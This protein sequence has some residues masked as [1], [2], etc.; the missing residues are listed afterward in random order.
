[1]SINVNVGGNTGPLERDVRAAMDRINRAGGLKIRVD[2]KGVTQP[3]GNMKRSADEFTKSLEASNAR[4]LAFGASVGMINAVSNAFKGLVEQTMK[5]E[6]NLTDINVVM[7][8]T[9]K[10]LDKF[11]GGLFKVAA[12]T[13]AGFQAASEAATEFARQGLSVAETLKRTKDALVLTRLTG[14]K[15][16]ESVK[17][18][19]AAMNTFKGEVH[20]STVLVSKFAAVDVKFAVSAEDFAQA[21]ARAGASARDA[22]VD[23]N[24]LIGI[25]TAVQERTARGGAVIGNAFKT[26][27]TRLRRSSTLQELENIGIAVRDVN[28]AT[29]PAMRILEKLAGKYDHL[30]DAQKSYIAQNVAGVFQINMLKAAMA[31]LGQANNVTAQATAI[32]SKATDESTQKNEQLRNTMSALAAETGVAIQE[33]AKKIGDIAL[34]PGI[35]KI[36]DGIKG[37]ADWANNLLG[38]G[39]KEGNRFAK[40]LL[41][42][43]GSFISGPGLILITAVVSKLFVNAAKYGLSSLNSLLGMNKAATAR[44]QTEQAILQVMASNEALSKEMLR[45]DIS[46][47]KKEQMILN[48]IRQQTTEAQKLVAVS[49]QLSIPLIRQGVQPNLSLRRAEGFIPNFAADKSERQLA[50]Q[51]GYSAGAIKQMNIPGVGDVTYN[52]AETVKKFPGMTQPAIMPPEESRAAGPYAAAFM[53]A[54]GF[55]PYAGHGYVPNYADQ[56]WATSVAAGKWHNDLGTASG[57]DFIKSHGGE[58]AAAAKLKAYVAKNPAAMALSPAKLFAQHNLRSTKAMTK[59]DA[60]A[61]MLVPQEGYKSMSTGR[62]GMSRY[63]KKGHTLEWPVHAITSKGKMKDA[64][65]EKSL[66]NKIDSVGGNYALNLVKAL[67][68]PDFGNPEGAKKAFRKKWDSDKAGGATGAMGSMVG[69]IFEAATNA[70]L[71]Y[72]AEDKDSAEGDFD[73]RGGDW[74]KIK[75]A[76]N[77]PG[78]LRYMLADYKNNS[79]SS[80][81]RESFYKKVMAQKKYFNRSSK[82]AKSSKQGLAAAAMGYIPNYANPLS[83]AIGRERG[84][85]VPVSKIRVGSHRALQAS[86]NPMGLGVTNTTDEPRGLKDVFGADGFV[87]NYAIGDWIGGTKMGQA[88]GSA[89]GIENAESAAQKL[90]DQYEKLT[91]KVSGAKDAHKNSNKTLSKRVKEEDKL[92]KEVRQLKDEQA[93]LRRQK[94]RSSHITAQL[95]KKEQDLAAA[96][97]RTQAARTKSSHISS[98]LSAKESALAATTTQL[99]SARKTARRRT[100]MAGGRAN[101]GMGLMMSAHMISGMIQQSDP[102]GTDKF[103]QGSSG[104]LSGAT[105]GAMVGAAIGSIIPGVGTALGGL[106]GAAIGAGIG[107]KNG[108]DNAQKALDE[109][110]KA[111]EEAARALKEA[112]EATNATAT[113]QV[114]INSILRSELLKSSVGFS[115]TRGQVGFNSFDMSKRS[116][117]GLLGREQMR[118]AGYLGLPGTNPNI[119]H[120]VGSVIDTLQRPGVVKS[121]GSK[122]DSISEIFL[123]LSQGKNTDIKKA[124]VQK[125]LE[126]ESSVIGSLRSA[127]RMFTGVDHTKNTDYD[128]DRNLQISNGIPMKRQSVIVDDPDLGQRLDHTMIP[129]TDREYA[130]NIMVDELSKVLKTSGKDKDQANFA[131]NNDSVFKSMPKDF[132]DR[133]ISQVNA[134]DGDHEDAQHIISS[135]FGPT[136]MSEYEKSLNAGGFNAQRGIAGGLLRNSGGSSYIDIKKVGKEEQERINISNKDLATIIDG[137]EGEAAGVLKKLGAASGPDDIQRIRKKLIEELEASAKEQTASKEGVIKN[138]HY[139]MVE[140]KIQQAKN[141]TLA[142][143]KRAHESETAK[144]KRLNDLLGAEITAEQKVLDAYDQ[145][146]ADI[147]KSISGK[148]TTADSAFSSGLF[149]AITSSSTSKIQFNTLFGSAAENKGQ[150][151]DD[152]V[153]RLTGLF[154]QDGK[155]KEE[156]AN[157][158]AKGFAA[159]LKKAYENTDENADNGTRLAHAFSQLNAELVMSVIKSEEF[160][161]NNAELERKVAKTADLH[162]ETN[163]ELDKEET[164]LTTQ[165]ILAKQAQET[166]AKTK[167]EHK[168]TNKILD[169]RSKMISNLNSLEK[170]SLDLAKKRRAL[171]QGPG[172]I[173]RSTMAANQLADAGTAG[174]Q[175][176]NAIRRNENLS[177]ARFSSQQGLDI[178]RIEAA[179]SEG[180][181][182]ERL[183]A[184]N[185]EMQTKQADR[186]LESQHNQSMLEVIQERVRIE[187]DL[188]RQKEEHFRGEDSFANG[189][190]DAAKAAYDRTKDF[191]YEMG[192]TIPEAFATSMSDAMMKLSREGGSFGDAMRG[193]AISMLDKINQKFTENF[194]NNMMAGFGLNED[195]QVDLEQQAK[196]ELTTV[197]DT[198]T[199]SIGRLGVSTEDAAAR[200]TAAASAIDLAATSIRSAAS[201]ASLGASVPGVGTTAGQ[202]HSPW[203]PPTAQ[204]IFGKQYQGGPVRLNK[205]GQVPSMLTN[206][207]F[208]MGKETVSRLGIG[209]MAELNQ[210]RIPKFNEG[211]FAEGFGGSLASGAGA[212][213]SGL[214]MKE[215]MGD[216]EDRHKKWERPKDAFEQNRAWKRNKMSANFMRNS[217]GVRTEVGEARQAKEKELQKWIAKQEEKQALGRQVVQLI[218]NAVTAGAMK[219]FGSDT[220]WGSKEGKS[221]FDRVDAGLGINQLGRNMQSWAMEKQGLPSQHQRE[222]PWSDQFL[223][224]QESYDQIQED[225]N[226]HQGKTYWTGLKKKMSWTGRYTGGKI[227]GPAGIDKVPAMLTE[228]EYVINANAARKI[229]IPALE[230][231]NAGRFN[232][233]GLV[234]ETTK[235]SEASSVGGMTNNINI[236]VNVEGGDAKD[237]AKSGDSSGSDQKTRMDDLSKKIKQQVVMVIKEENRP[238]GLLG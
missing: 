99:N 224:R 54:H 4:V 27:F 170:S 77:I 148:R 71:R 9:A 43:V 131:I 96:T 227:T 66:Q 92:T 61:A 117:A 45:T 57:R 182:P 64:N 214:L 229:G 181:T 235:S 84:A 73:V 219:E 145:K 140:Q 74:A 16:T 226:A 33:L 209:S 32:A 103:A 216:D 34:A 156:D 137:S 14:M 22:G 8:L 111:E 130:H 176:M 128:I 82:G 47:E 169:L 56:R 221:A 187:K 205:G 230:K 161:G 2:D 174:E 127:G 46:R 121:D 202:V 185:L 68:E 158:Q 89:S 58:D 1:M 86:S 195:P 69:A 211:G 109:K 172:Y 59:L 30:S 107:I 20:D 146:T 123:G 114:M 197:T 76:F 168:K 149:K 60:T 184:M 236:S 35:N 105:S 208:V 23:I 115:A 83:D 29:L 97:A 178:A 166:Y 232:E 52:T 136:S 21:I 225:I 50:Q 49:R 88:M 228:G 212:M 231:I 173:L 223:N 12:E 213:A 188:I 126:D 200:M 217:E 31:D 5:V 85:G 3:L 134:S 72:S 28:G 98:Q 44:K 234:G 112:T 192:K 129:Y 38:D 141:A 163:L 218:G 135:M 48:L 7:G 152:D 138:I 120:S 133:L 162:K 124:V 160:V 155:V 11:G 113:S 157:K 55:S 17:S 87:P 37:V 106:A 194:A 116:D 220:G 102:D 24:E 94:V 63:T 159:K 101:M 51:A 139:Q 237:G 104:G 79:A 183:T 80:E 67:E 201:K 153:A 147:K 93:K 118:R 150:L 40:G 177:S 215:L 165:N 204:S 65:I 19:T 39:E 90:A 233:G 222:G 91:K 186:M 125:R 25:V 206:G 110:A 81:N 167:D 142:V 198:A 62:L 189:M 26:I 207:E 13:G 41:A 108:A 179:K 95:N 42:G 75:K 122:T 78:G 199:G 191:K 164:F 151:G 119:S 100:S 70:A 210:G 132:R 238:G 143:Q 144:R 203:A 53:G 171:T 193:A 180:A 18:L 190:N 10:Q 175:E 6:K 15:A 154:S 36:L 196:I